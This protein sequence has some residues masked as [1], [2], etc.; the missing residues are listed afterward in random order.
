M[1]NELTWTASRFLQGE[2]EA[3]A[4]GIHY[5]VTNFPTAGRAA[6]ANFAAADKID[7]GRFEDGPAGRRAAM[8]ACQAHADAVAVSM[9]P[10]RQVSTAA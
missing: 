5:R 9:H 2:W 3:E 1:T 10:M 8:E 6:G 7:L 4:N